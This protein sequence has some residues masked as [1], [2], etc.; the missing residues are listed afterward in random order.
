M[1]QQ[2]GRAGSHGPQFSAFEDLV[3]WQMGQIGL[4]VTLAEHAEVMHCEAAN[5][6][7]VFFAFIIKSIKVAERQM[8]LSD[9]RSLGFAETRP[10]HCAHFTQPARKVASFDIR[11]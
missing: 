7:G 2:T 3:G 6:F 4:W 9:Y 11:F 5:H 10:A 8:N 1:A